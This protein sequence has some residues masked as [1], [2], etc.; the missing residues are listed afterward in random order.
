MKSVALLLSAA[1]PLLAAP[2]F[3]A[4]KVYDVGKL[5]FSP[6]AAEKTGLTINDRSMC[7]AAAGSNL[8][9][10]WQDAYKQHADRGATPPDG[11]APD[12]GVSPRG[13]AYLNIY[14]AFLNSWTDGS[15]LNPDS[16]S[17]WLQGRQLMELTAEQKKLHHVSV[18]NGNPA[19]G[20]YTS[21]FREPT[22]WVGGKNG[23]C[24]CIVDYGTT[25]GND[26]QYSPK[27]QEEVQRILD[28]MLR[29]RGQAGLLAFMHFER[30][31]DG[32]MQLKGGH[33]VSCWGYEKD[34][35]GKL[36]ALY[37][38]DSDDQRLSVFR[39][40]TAEV[41]GAVA[42][43][44]DDP[45]SRYSM[46]PDRCLIFCALSY[47]NT[48]AEVAQG[49][50]PADSLPTD[51]KV[52]CN[53]QL[54]APAK[55][56]QLMIQ[57]GESIG[58]T[59]FSA[60]SS[61]QCS[62]SLLIEHGALVS[63]SAGGA[64]VTYE[65]ETLENAG[66]CRV[67]HGRLNARGLFNAGYMDLTELGPVALQACHSVGCMTLSGSTALQ[68]GPL[69]LR[70][71]ERQVLALGCGELTPAGISCPQAEQGRSVQL[72][73]AVAE[74][75]ESLCLKNVTLSGHCRL[76]AAQGVVLEHV[77]Y[78]PYLPASF[79]VEDGV[80]TVDCRFLVEGAAEGDLTLQWKRADVSRL[81]AAGVKRVHVLLG[82]EVNVTLR[83]SGMRS[84]ADGGFEL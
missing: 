41:G 66:Q 81:K 2:T 40:N 25:P 33:A 30:M 16:L 45:A 61:L 4:G 63:L 55:A 64:G 13:T 54:T 19:G 68:I 42:L 49:G 69:C 74:S 79:P 83:A 12:N 82:D 72:R 23:P 43:Y 50:A 44:S 51:G 22:H 84:A 20:Y 60:S 47:I 59:I 75:S 21:L 37:L 18:R 29:T 32:R 5:S 77:A 34:P 28:E 76:K 8:L 35:S 38:T 36:C 73:D 7:W 27:T 26:M 58:Q 57:A 65:A 1:L 10:H 53:T 9:Q 6:N 62:G 15:G 78:V 3:V 67:A 14:R 17:W 80:L 56:E 39:V 11:L 48:P 70:A 52:C 46:S 71:A 24:G 31:P